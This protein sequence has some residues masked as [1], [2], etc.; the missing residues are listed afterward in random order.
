MEWRA[1]V[2]SPVCA[3]FARSHQPT[4]LLPADVSTFMT[5]KALP[6]TSA[7]RFWTLGPVGILF[8]DHIDGGSAGELR[9]I[10]R[11]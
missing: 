1:S 11:F 2:Q 6:I 8:L 5:C 4:G 10:G 9:H 7:G 3:G